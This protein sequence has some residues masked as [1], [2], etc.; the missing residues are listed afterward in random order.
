MTAAAGSGKTAVL[1]ERC[2]YLVC[3]APAPFRCDVDALLVLTFTK[4]AAAEMR[5]RIVSA[6]RSRAHNHPNT[7]RLRE[8]VALADAAQIST[9]HAFCLWMVQRWFN[10]AGVDPAAIPLDEQESRLLRC[11]VLDGV[12]EALY[13][14]QP[15]SDPPLGQ[16]RISATPTGQTGEPG[17]TEAPD[18]GQAFLRLVEVYGLG[19]DREIGKFVRALFEFTTSL[20]DPDQW[21]DAAASAPRSQ[22]DA[23]IL[24]VLSTL[25]DELRR[26]INHCDDVI[27]EMTCTHG[28]SIMARQKIS[29]YTD[30]L[31]NWLSTLTPAATGDTTAPSPTTQL[32]TYASVCQEIDAFEFSKKLGSR[33]S[34]D[35]DASIREEVEKARATLK[36]VKD[37]LYTKRLHERYALFTLEEWR[38]GLR[39]VAPFTATIIELVRRFR[40]AYAER[41]RK[42]NVLD[43]SDLER[44]AYRLLRSET[45]ATQPSA[46]ARE[47]H[48]RF[49]HVL[50]DE[51]QDVNPLQQEI[52][53]LVSHESTEN[54]VG[55]LFVVGDVKQS[56][57]R[58]RLAK[59]DF[60]V[61]RLHRFR[62][63]D[64]AGEAIALQQNFRSRAHL[65]DAVNMV[66][67]SL[68]PRGT[69]GIEYDD[70]A[71]LHP[72]RTEPATPPTPIELHLLERDWR[73]QAH[74]EDDDERNDDTTQPESTPYEEPPASLSDDPREWS[75]IEREGRLIGRRIQ[76]WMQT[77][78]GLVDEE[79]LRYGDIAVLIRAAKTNAER[80]AAMLSKMG[81]PAHADTGG[82][83]FA[84]VEVRDVL[85][86]LELLDNARQD[87]PLAAVMR[88]GVLGIRFSE[89]DLLTIRLID[90]NDDFHHV[91]RRYVGEGE[92]TELRE[93]LSVFFQRLDL[94]RHESRRRP[95]ADILWKI[96]GELGHLAYASGMIHGAKRRA[97]LLK[98][99]ELAR[100]FGSF[101]RQGLH[102]FLR[103]IDAMDEAD[104]QLPLASSLGESEDVVRIMSV[105]KS[106]GLEFPV[107]FLAGLGNKFHLGDRTG[108]MIHQ[109]HAKI[110]LH[111]I[112]TDRMIEYPSASHIRVINED[113][114]ESL[115]EELRI[116]YVAMTRARDRLVLVG[117]CRHAEEAVDRLDRLR[118]KEVSSFVR[119]TAKTPL[120]WLL[121]AIGAAR[122]NT[123]RSVHVDD[124]A[125]PPGWFRVHAHTPE[126]MSAWRC[127][128]VHADADLQ[129]VR[130]AVVSLQRLPETEPTNVDDAA[131][132]AVRACLDYVYPHLAT[133]SV[134]ATFAASQH[135]TDHDFTGAPQPPVL[136]DQPPA[137]EWPPSK[138]ERAASASPTERGTVT[139]RVLQHLDYTAAKDE[140]GLAR[141][142]QRLVDTGILRAQERDVLDTDALAWFVETPLADAIRAAG[143]AYQREFSYVTAEPP[144]Y[145]DPSLQA[146]E[147]DFVLVRG[148]VD[149][150]LPVADG[151]E[152]IDFKTDAITKDDVAARVE[153]YRSQVML[154][155][156]AVSRIWH[157]PVTAR[158]LVFLTPHVIAEVT[159]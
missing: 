7:T 157:Q 123:T 85:S 75:A 33:L 133:T 122:P 147:G 97:N 151:V 15:K 110:G 158:R 60:F 108:R 8:Q 49:A 28:A 30:S 92:H 65:L 95:P 45:D 131:A 149:A 79:P 48:K 68:M 129:K 70:E 54:R 155:D 148:V 74:S 99:H 143:S 91:V 39:C 117:S 62:Q 16:A 66:F 146:P 124:T 152:V 22:A 105:H 100:Q 1:A 42:L 27:S 137:F 125:A 78:Q 25:P 19:H 136:A 111:V 72:G 98:L 142:L 34:K 126:M 88:S 90:K 116:L 37:T 86:A 57:Y 115:A 154:Y 36:T 14:Q 44:F 121:P 63:P 139:H 153:R 58:F 52:L 118:G 113:E 93:R 46:I 87:I 102:R 59:P 82:S 71:E 130:R 119:S 5:S 10:E 6:I 140:H 13:Q 29:D 103:F 50:V 94:M 55:N 41:K 61:E 96:Y 106:K 80:I 89:N 3:D 20:P 104:D 83:L 77:P 141:E 134:H 159:G 135:K 31:R 4:A 73:D 120:D 145:F 24:D 35:T 107:V 53:R 114:R 67:R 101:R 9:I 26:Q 12:F 156:R 43:F 32:E 40:E 150:I 11:E 132:A 112:D 64:T 38:E 127:P 81:I 17:H 69:G 23:I 2:A 51:F 138:Y 76:E 21:L 109:P 84:A 47:L 128:T 18:L 56:V 144:E